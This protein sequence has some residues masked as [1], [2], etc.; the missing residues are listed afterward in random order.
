[1]KEIYGELTPIDENRYRTFNRKSENE[2]LKVCLT[3]CFYL[4]IF[5]I[6]SDLKHLLR[7]P[8]SFAA[9]VFVLVIIACRTADSKMSS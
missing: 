5:N 4:N 8:M 1:M 3:S 2:L 6:Y 9:L 7:A